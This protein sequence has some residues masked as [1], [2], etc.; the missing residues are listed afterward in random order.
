MSREFASV[1]RPM[2]RTWPLR[3]PTPDMMQGDG[4]RPIPGEW[5]LVVWPLPQIAGRSWVFSGMDPSSPA[6]YV[7]PW[8]PKPGMI[9]Y[10]NFD[11]AQ[12]QD[13]TDMGGVWSLPTD[14]TNRNAG[15]RPR[16]L[17]RGGGTGAK[18]WGAGGR[19]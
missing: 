15:R 8:N 10:L 9:G 12:V 16:K 3:H 14:E 17:P 13:R 11:G 5:Q 1:T 4:S 18:W 19:R 6:T 2:W 7:R